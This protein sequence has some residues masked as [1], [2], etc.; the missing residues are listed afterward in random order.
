M[1]PNGKDKDDDAD[2]GVSDSSMIGKTGDVPEEDFIYTTNSKAESIL[3]TLSTESLNNEGIQKRLRSRQRLSKRLS[4]AY[5]IQNKEL[6]D[7]HY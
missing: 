5:E 1:S 6:D 4:K 7:I 2:S 3:A